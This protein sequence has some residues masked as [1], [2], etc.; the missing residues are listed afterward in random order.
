MN[1]RWRAP[2]MFEDAVDVEDVCL[3]PHQKAYESFLQIDRVLEGHKPESDVGLY[4]LLSRIFPIE[5]SPKSKRYKN[6]EY[7]KITHTDE[8]ALLEEIR[9]E[10]GD[11]FDIKNVFHNDY[12][13]LDVKDYRIIFPDQLDPQSP[14]YYK[15]LADHAWK[16]RNLGATLQCH[17]ELTITIES[18]RAIV[19]HAEPKGVIEKASI[20]IPYLFAALPIFTP[21]GTLILDGLERVPIVRLISYIRADKTDLEKYRIKSDLMSMDAWLFSDR[22]RHIIVKNIENYRKLA[23]QILDRFS[24]PEEISLNSLSDWLQ[25]HCIKPVCS[26]ELCPILE[27]TNPLS[28][29]SLKRKLTTKVRS[30]KT[31]ALMRERRGIY[32]SHYGRLCLVETPESE[33]IG[34]D[35]HLALAARIEKQKILSP[36]EVDGKTVWLTPEEEMSVSVIPKADSI[37][38]RDLSNQFL[39]RRGGEVCAVSELP[40]NVHQ[41]KYAA[42]FLGLAANL[43]PFVQHNDNN[44]VMMGAKNMKQALPLFKPE[45]PL[46]KTGREKLLGRLSGHGVFARKS[47]YVEAVLPDRIVVRTM[48]GAEDIYG[49]QPERPT[50]HQTITRQSPRVRKGDKVEK[51]QVLADGACTVTGELALGVNLLVAYMPYYGLNFEDGI[52]IS[53]RLVKDD[54][55]TSLHVRDV[56]FDVY[57]NQFMESTDMRSEMAEFSSKKGIL[58]KVDQAVQ[59]GDRLFVKYQQP[60]EESGTRPIEK[61]YFYSPIT[62]TVINIFHE[63]ETNE[64]GRQPVRFRKRCWILEKRQVEVGDKLMGRH[65]NKGVV[66]RIIPSAEMP[67]LENGTPVDVILNPHGVVSRMNLGQ[68]METHLG[69]ILHHGGKNFEHLGTVPPFQ[70]I[71]EETLKDAFR[72]L[73]HTGISETGKA[74]LIDGRSGKPIENPVVV[75]YQY[76]M[77]LNHLVSDKIHVRDTGLYTTMTQQPVKGQKHGGGQRVGEMEVWALESH[78]ARSVLA[79]MMTIKS[80]APA[81]NRAVIDTKEPRSDI[82][83]DTLVPETLTAA[84]ILLRGLGL[85][86]ILRDQQSQE[87]PLGP[88][89]PDTA[90]HD[91]KIEFTDENRVMQWAKHHIVSKPDKPSIDDGKLTGPPDS[92]FDR[93]IFSDKRYDMGCIRLPAP[94][95][96][97]LLVKHVQESAFRIFHEHFRDILGEVIIPDIDIDSDKT[98]IKK[99]IA[100][101]ILAK[102]VIVRTQ[103]LKKIE[104]VPVEKLQDIPAESD[105]WDR[106]DLLES[107]V[108][109]T[110]SDLSDLLTM[111]T[112]RSIPVLPL[113]FRPY[114]IRR[115]NKSIFSHIDIFYRQILIACQ[116]FGEAEERKE[117]RTTQIC[118]QT[119]IQQ[120]VNRLMIGDKFST[121]KKQI[122][123]ADMIRGKEGIF[124]KFLLGKRVDYSGRSVIVPM[125]ELDF[126]NAGIPV[127]IAI[128]LT[129]DI[130]I[131]RLT[132]EH[133]DRKDPLDRKREALKII[134]EPDISTHRFLIEKKLTGTNG[135]LSKRVMIL[136]RAPSLHKYNLISFKPVLTKHRA[137]GLHPLLCKMFNADF[138]GDQMAVHLPISAESV[139]EANRRMTPEANI[140][141]VANGKPILNFTQDIVLGL[142]HLSQKE[143]GK[144]Q[145]AEWFD[146]SFELVKDLTA[147]E[148]EK[149]LFV[150]LSSNPDPEKRKILLQ[151]LMNAGFAEATLSGLTFSIFDTP[152]ISFEERRQK[153]ELNGDIT[154]LKKMVE[155]S[156]VEQ[157]KDSD[158]PVAKMVRSGAKGGMTQIT[159]L[160]GLRGMMTDMFDQ[161]IQTP[162]C[163]NYREGISPLEFFIGSH[164]SRRSMCEKK[165]I[166]AE[167]GA[168]TRRLVESAYRFVIREEDC[169]N[170]EDGVLL[171]PVPQDIQKELGYKLEFADRLT[172]RVL[173]D[174]TIIDP[175]LAET[176]ADT[177]QAVKVRSVVSCRSARSHG[178]GALCQHCYGWD[179]S[180]RRFPDMGSPVGIIA[181]QSIGERGTQLSMQTFHTGGVG[182]AGITEGLPKIKKFFNDKPIEMETYR[183]ID[184]GN[185]DLYCKREPSALFEPPPQPSPAG[186]GSLRETQIMPVRS[187]KKDEIIDRWQWIYHKIHNPKLVVQKMDDQSPNE[188]PASNSRKLSSTL[189]W[190][191]DAMLLVLHLESWRTYKGDIHDRH[192]EVIL[193]SMLHPNDSNPHELLGISKT[194]FI[195]PGFL[196]A[197]SYQ[198]ALKVLT[199]AALEKRT[200]KIEGYKERIIM[201]KMI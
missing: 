58:C 13:H 5:S 86:L 42:Q 134:N 17:I 16:Y 87:I 68:I 77:K 196:A 66:S 126:G 9:F 160:G 170:N 107:L 75:G 101:V 30:G 112:I 116:K 142:Y 148:L 158:S 176:L 162:V 166:T 155:R 21:H 145:I 187:I 3:S 60:D 56:S 35:L 44:R 26:A 164:A 69:W 182:S 54:L 74:V 10:A 99:E 177:G 106:F 110:E 43:I 18:R 47:G 199:S 78:L 82:L 97:P 36:L 192:F 27:D 1:N 173:L 171:H 178:Y 130:L 39:I 154:A 146:I 14:E 188:N 79:E 29:I 53:D 84:I 149:Q 153:Q 67:R 8:K 49:I 135:L 161:P 104:F 102:K 181:G 119:G 190:G 72:N 114:S 159:Q 88:E 55:L 120:A 33:S 186:G 175:S 108:S 38:D 23:V 151:N 70:S 57:P 168:F 52:V 124:R 89:K 157:S 113:D 63:T 138:D 45:I 4:A 195:Q 51:G 167:A 194:P 73:S 50:S 93:K 81:P 152:Y 100:D 83:D 19:Y 122:P 137:I 92:L 180:T 133:G 65:G 48:D 184:T 90:I 71:S 98:K 76:I 174:G 198:S 139:E 200:D 7:V 115:G 163:R 6:Q 95:I 179:L 144:R 80:D 85:D 201:G 32:A 156:L 62:G 185:S 189:E 128:G 131:E 31:K 169:G 96:H 15:N 105:I 172:G 193:R 140:L 141:S 183:V 46:V 191:M 59:K 34:L 111:A 125:P 12:F 91:V 132:K 109:Y 136:N 2:L 11:S 22:L 94:V 123:I 147:S 64:T 197:A 150:F 41:D 118:L 103:D 143:T 61:K 37:Y 24:S 25:R 20:D 28:E 121:E 40:E 129:R 117:P 165:L 127:D